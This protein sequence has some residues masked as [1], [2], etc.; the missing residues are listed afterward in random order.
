MSLEKE[1]KSRELMEFP[2]GS[3]RKG[4]MN[5]QSMMYFMTLHLTAFDHFPKL[6]EWLRK[7]VSPDL[8]FLT[9]DGWF[10]RG[11][12]HLEK[13]KIHSDGH[14][15]PVLRSGKFVWALALAESG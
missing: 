15:H 8:E 2:K 13:G 4:V 7:F 14:W 1:C 10:E 6:K 11:H 12:N 9:A 3:F 5:G